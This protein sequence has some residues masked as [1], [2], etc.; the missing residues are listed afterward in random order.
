MKVLILDNYDSFTYNLFHYVDQLC[1][2]VVVKRNDEISLEE[3]GE[4]SHIIISPGP[5]LPKDAGITM[6]LLEKFHQSKNIFGVC[7]GCQAI[8]EFFGGQLYNQQLVAHGIFRNVK[9]TTPSKLLKD[10]PSEFKVGLYHS[11]A[12]DEKSLPEELVITSKSEM[13]TVMSLE[14]Q[15]Y[16]VCGVQFHPESIMTEGGLQIIKNWLE[17]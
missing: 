1:D 13:G 15:K 3:V 5:G 7:L 12:I 11:W 6:S 14:H 16:A 4:F 8:A 2:D 10:L 17:S 9:Q